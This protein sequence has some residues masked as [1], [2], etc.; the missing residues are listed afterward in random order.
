MRYT[1]LPWQI[2]STSQHQ[3]DVCEANQR[4]LGSA[5]RLWAMDHHLPE[6]CPAPP[7]IDLIPKYL[8][9]TPLC[10][11]G[12]VYRFGSPDEDVQCSLHGDLEEY[13]WHQF[14]Q[15]DILFPHGNR[16]SKEVILE[17]E[18]ERSLRRQE[19]DIAQEAR[20]QSA[21]PPPSPRFSD[22]PTVISTFRPLQ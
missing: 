8:T 4:M 22:I 21:S 19:S 13:D 14:D 10:P 2:A 20:K 17:V 1:I 16:P 7:L 15:K 12:G 9:A 6:N 5:I 3:A 18:R 11:T